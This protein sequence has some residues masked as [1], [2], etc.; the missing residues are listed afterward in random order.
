MPES[1]KT[2]PVFQAHGQFDPLVSLARAEESRAILQQHGV[3]VE[4]H[5]YPMEHSVCAEE[6]IDISRWLTAVLTRPDQS[7]GD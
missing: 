3:K 5:A 2:V 1:N 7:G 6:I 4:W